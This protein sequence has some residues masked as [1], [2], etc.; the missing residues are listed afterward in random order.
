MFTWKRLR[1]E[2]TVDVSS[3]K[4]LNVLLSGP[5]YMKTY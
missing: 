3:V 1:G 2:R 5:H 4:I